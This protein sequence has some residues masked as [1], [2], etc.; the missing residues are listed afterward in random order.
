MPCL[1]EQRRRA[2]LTYS[3]LWQLCVPSGTSW[4]R[5]RLVTLMYV[6]SCG[7]HNLNACTQTCMYTCVR[8]YMNDHCVHVCV[9]TCFSLCCLFVYMFVCVCLCVFVC[10]CVHVYACQRKTKDRA[11]GMREK[12]AH[13]PRWDSNLYLWNTRRS[14][15]P[16]TPRGQARL[17]SV[18][19]NTLD[20]HPPA[21]SWNTNIQRNTPTPICGTTTSGICKDL[22]W[23]G[24]S[25]SG[26]DER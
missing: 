9:R 8:V 11:D 20:T 24:Q 14:C 2:P 3:M 18:E 26:K 12:S 23:V 6:C 5:P 17:T 22:R 19:T 1:S 4:C 7:V 16:I 25:V 15:F 13:S 21:P 10:M